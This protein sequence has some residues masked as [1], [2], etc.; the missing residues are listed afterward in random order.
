[1]ILA[2]A[3]IV[4]AQASGSVVKPEPSIELLCRSGYARNIRSR[5]SRS[6]KL[7]VYRREGRPRDGSTV[8]DHVIP[9]VLGGHP[10]DPENLQLQEKSESRMKDWV[11]VRLYREVCRGERSLRSAQEIVAKDWR[12]FYARE[13][14]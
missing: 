9:L 14:R 7:R 4:A 10:D 11:E 2:V 12:G 5:L 8:V 1:M 6:E 13:R 3:A